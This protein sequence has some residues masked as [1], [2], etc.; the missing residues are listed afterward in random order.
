MTFEEM[1]KELELLNYEWKKRLRAIRARHSED[2]DLKTCQTIYPGK[3]NSV[4]RPGDHYIPHN[5]YCSNFDYTIGRFRN[6]AINTHLFENAYRE[7]V[8]SDQYALKELMADSDA[9]LISQG[10]TSEE[11]TNH[12]KNMSTLLTPPSSRSQP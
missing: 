6:P 8:E 4:M 12:F 7:L 2:A 1:E 11:P 10:L 3:L 9:D 5:K